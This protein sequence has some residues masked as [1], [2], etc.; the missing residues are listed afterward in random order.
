[1]LMRSDPDGTSAATAVGRTIE[2]SRTAVGM[3]VAELARASGIGRR[4]VR[5]IERGATPDDQELS[6]LAGA[7]GVAPAD[8]VPPGTNLRL[9]GGDGRA[10]EGAEALDA[11]LRE[12]ISMVIEMRDADRLPAATLREEDLTE[13][14][15]ALGGSPEAIEARLIELIGTDEKGAHDLRS[16]ILPSVRVT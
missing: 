11:L 9:L 16:T 7:C 4:R 3:S 6:A 13:L 12:Y 10:L 5:A 2:A 1:M 15:R 14:A 8:L